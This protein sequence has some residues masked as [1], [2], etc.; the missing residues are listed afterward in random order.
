[1]KYIVDEEEQII[2]TINRRWTLTDRVTLW[3]ELPKKRR[4]RVISE[5]ELDRFE[6]LDHYPKEF[7]DDY[8]TAIDTLETLPLIDKENQTNQAIK[9]IQALLKIIS[10]MKNN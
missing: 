6:M 4:E 5:I 1:M 2:D 8:L 3:K 9:D 10:K 7:V